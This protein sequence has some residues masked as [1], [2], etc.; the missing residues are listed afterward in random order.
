[1][2]KITEIGKRFAEFLKI[3]LA[4]FLR[5]ALVTCQSDHTASLKR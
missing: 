3:T 2:Q 5:H 1:M 4:P